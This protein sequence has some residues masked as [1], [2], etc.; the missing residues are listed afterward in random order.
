[1]VVLLILAGLGV[2]VYLVGKPTNIAPK[3]AGP[4][5]PVSAPI[6][7]RPK[8]TRSPHPSGGD[9]VD[10]CHKTDSAQNPYVSISIDQNALEQ[11]KQHGDIYP[12]PEDGCP[13]RSTKSPR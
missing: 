12:V 10:I 11:H 7:P 8:P 2:G 3:A 5:N 1:M 9:R 13:Q 4:K 6:I